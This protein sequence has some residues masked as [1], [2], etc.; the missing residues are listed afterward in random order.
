[1]AAIQTF[2]NLQDKV[3]AWLDEA[4][5]TGT[6]LTL[7]K[8]GL[9]EAN[10]Q[11]ATQ[12]R[13]TW[14]KWDT[15]ELLQIVI[16]Q[17]FYTLHAEYF[18]PD[19]FW[20]RGQLDYVEQVDEA[21]IGSTKADWNTDTAPAM[22][23]ILRGRTEVQN[24][25]TSASFLTATSSSG[26]DSAATVVIKGDTTQ[27]V[28]TETLTAGVLGTVSFTRILKVTK[29]GTWLGTLT[30]TSNA[31]AVN[32]LFL[33]SEENGRSYQQIFFLA[34]PDTADVIEYIF[35]RQPAVM[36]LDNDRPD[37][38]TPFEEL[39][40][41]DTLM[42]FAG[43]NSYDPTVVQ[44]WAQKQAQQLLALEQTEDARAIQAR[45]NYTEYIYR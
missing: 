6:T 9:N 22:Q 24:Q 32:N 23:F 17:R 3:L 34:L 29:V 12:Q 4:G 28:R 2:K 39:L 13:W 19:Y 20:N 27:G 31:G 42:A 14:M 1:M 10:K 37:V 35:Y 11:R 18:R 45:T 36:T 33:F 7:V 25:P 8:N 30:L 38:P 44:V 40:V 21:T 43:Y 26:S 5:D 15:A 16:G 41:W